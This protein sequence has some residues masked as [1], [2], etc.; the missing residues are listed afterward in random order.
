MSTELVLPQHLYRKSA[1]KLAS[2]FWG[3]DIV[4]KG[5]RGN[6]AESVIPYERNRASVLQMLLEVAR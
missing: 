1:G 6:V 3:A 2:L 5:G 4:V